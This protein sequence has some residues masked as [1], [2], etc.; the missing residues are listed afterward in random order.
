M[1]NARM[2]TIAAQCAA[3]AAAIATA[4][5]GGIVTTDV[6]A[7]AAVLNLLALSPDIITPLISQAVTPPGLGGTYAAPATTMLN[8]N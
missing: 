4:M 3:N 1:A 6:Q 7:L 5:A 2:S 8:P